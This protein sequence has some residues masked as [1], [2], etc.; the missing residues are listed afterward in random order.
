MVRLA[1]EM[2][3]IECSDAAVIGDTNGDMRMGRAACAAVSIGIHA[4]AGS[5]DGQRVLADA[6]EM[7]SAYVQLSIR[8]R[9]DEG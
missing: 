4:A 9:F 1:C 3:S 6:D 5:E 7:I 2:L 8:R